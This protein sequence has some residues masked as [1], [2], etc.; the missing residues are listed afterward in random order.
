VEVPKLDATRGFS[1]ETPDALVVV[2]GTRFSVLVEPTT[3]G[4]R[5]RVQVTRGIVAVQKGGR[6]VFL[7]AGQAWPVVEAAPAAATRGSAPSASMNEPV[8]VDAGLDEADEARRPS[9]DEKKRG[10][11]SQRKPPVFDSRELADQNRRFARAMTAK[12][13]GDTATALR[14]LGAILRRYPGSPLTQETRVE[15]LRL[16]RGVGRGELAAREARRYL[17]E[18]PQGYAVLEAEEALS[19]QP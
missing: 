9:P 8:R 6:E 19:G 10:R 2:H 18:F 15:R 13:Q 14:E 16:L 12:K 5:T 3:D 1:V 17:R 7:T 4:P 11:A